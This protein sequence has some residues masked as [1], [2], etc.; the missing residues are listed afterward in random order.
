VKDIEK[1]GTQE[2]SIAYTSSGRNRGPPRTVA[3]AIVSHLE[4]SRIGYSWAPMDLHDVADPIYS[5]FALGDSEMVNRD[6]EENS[7]FT[8]CCL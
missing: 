6:A 3:L 7:T 4:G 1:C 5:T 8:F 2:T